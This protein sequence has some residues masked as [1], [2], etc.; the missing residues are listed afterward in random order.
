MKIFR[1]TDD[2]CTRC[3][4]ITGNGRDLPYLAPLAPFNFYSLDWEDIHGEL[5]FYDFM[6]ERFAN[7]DVSLPLYLFEID[8]RCWRTCMPENLAHLKAFVEKFQELY[9]I[10]Q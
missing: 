6:E 10:P 9:S 3:H 2:E 7:E 4:V 1:I 5:P 8:R